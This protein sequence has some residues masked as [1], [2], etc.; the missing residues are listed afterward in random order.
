MA[1][2]PQILVLVHL[3]TNLTRHAPAGPL[4]AGLPPT[5]L[6]TRSELQVTNEQL[7]QRGLACEGNIR[8]LLEGNIGLY[9]V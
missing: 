8:A 6:S 4:P 9:Y 3:T 2:T 5:L 7:Q 1:H